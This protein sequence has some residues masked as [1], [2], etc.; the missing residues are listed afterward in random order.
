MLAQWAVPV[1]NI[2]IRE[3]EILLVIPSACQGSIEPF[4]NIMLVAFLGRFLP[5]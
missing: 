4:G 1:M 2:A 3:S 5:P